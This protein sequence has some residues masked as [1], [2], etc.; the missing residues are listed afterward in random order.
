LAVLALGLLILPCSARDARA[1]DIVQRVKTLAPPPAGAFALAALGSELF[2]RRGDELWKTDGTPGGTMRVGETLTIPFSELTSSGG[3]VFFRGCDAII[4][5]GTWRTDGTAPGTIRLSTAAIYVETTEFANGAWYFTGFDSTG[6]EPW[7]SDG[8]A[9]GTMPLADLGPGSSLDNFEAAIVGVGPDVFIAALA[10]LWVSDGTTLGTVEVVPSSVVTNPR[11]I[12]DLNGIAIFRGTSGGGTGREIWR[13]DGTPGGT[14]EIADLEPGPGGSLPERFVI[15]GSEVF[16]RA[17]TSALGCEL[18][19]TDGTTASLVLDVLPGAQGSTPA[20]LRVAGGLLFF[21]ASDAAAGRELWVS[22]GTPGGTVRVKDIYPGAPSSH[23]SSLAVMGSEVLFAANDGITGR[24]LWR[25]DGTSAGTVRVAD[26]FP[27][28]G[29]TVPRAVSVAGLT[30]FF[31][32]TEPGGT[33]RLF[34]TQGT[35]ATTSALVPLA[36]TYGS[37]VYP[38]VPI[39][40]QAVFSTRN[41]IGYV[42]VWFT[43]GTGAG[44]VPLDVAAGVD[45]I[46]FSSVFMTDGFPALL[47]IFDPNHGIELWSTDGTRAGTTLVKDVAPGPVSS[48]SYPFSPPL[49]GLRYFPANDLVH[50]A[51]L[52]RTDGTPAGTELAVDIEPGP[53]SSSP[54]DIATYG[55]QLVFGAS[56]LATGRELWVSDGTPIGTE[57]LDIVPG[58]GG[59]APGGAAGIFEQGRARFEFAIVGGLLL[60]SADTPGLGREP[61]VTNGTLA[62]TQLLADIHGGPTTGMNGSARSVRPDLAIF[63]ADDGVHGCELW[64]TDGTGAGTS[65]LADL[66]PGPGWSIAGVSYFN[67]CDLDGSAPTTDGSFLYFKADDGVHGFEPWRTDGTPAGTIPLGDLEPG[68]GGSMASGYFSGLVFNG[69]AYFSATTSAAGQEVWR[70]DGSAAGTVQVTDGP[71]RYIETYSNLGGTLFAGVTDANENSELWTILLECGDGALDAGEICDDGNTDPGD[72]CAEDCTLENEVVNVTVPAGGSATTD[73]EQ[74][75]ATAGDPA[76][77][78]VFTPNAGTIT[79]DEGPAAG[80]PGE[81]YDILGVSMVITAPPATP[82]D[83]LRLVF[84]FDATVIPPGRDEQSIRIFRNDVLVPACTGPVG[85]AVPDPC[86]AGRDRL[87]DGDALFTVLTSAASVWTF[88]VDLCGDTPMATCRAPFVA[89][90]ATLDLKDKPTDKSDLAK[91]GWKPGTAT[92]LAALGDPTSTTNYGLCVYDTVGDAPRLRLRAIAPAGGTCS[93]KPCWTSKGAKGFNYKSRTATPDGIKTMKVVPGID[94]KA[95][96]GVVAGGE[97]LP[98]PVL[99]L[100]VDGHVTAQVVNDLGECWGATFSLPSRND[101]FQFKAKAD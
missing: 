89:N 100:S 32:G 16:F 95:Q 55:S 37:L 15:M 4:G 29:S 35:P 75:G 34:A 92:A 90:K 28:F 97:P 41:D 9:A 11:E 59:S 87:S 63:A 85:E 45:G 14:Y 68:A 71:W 6:T 49:G 21:T 18:W 88:A 93:G 82:S 46:D 101:T 20:S 2:F 19:K 50:G 13:S 58:P 66:N 96:I 8:T 7:R 54:G 24:E 79:I 83:P 48:R 53:G 17:C 86:I 74:N 78:T 47:P 94:G 67:G 98:M 80:A 61:W 5:C 25:S 44:T 64:V 43:D 36:P 72:G 62:G 57:P 51:E 31:A 30:A 12:V 65:L 22:D 56:T 81:G 10:S 23:P 52:W 27:S 40:D 73:P 26:I 38:P 84:Q 99:P 91:L 1:S 60:F 33:H 77:I 76:E 69:K 3:F 39:G 70:T 42:D